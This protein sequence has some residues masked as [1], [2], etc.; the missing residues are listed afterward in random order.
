MNGSQWFGHPRGL[1]TLFFTEM[2]ERFSYYGMRAFL[3]LYMTAAVA[4]G[5]LG[6]DDKHAATVYGNYVGAVWLTPIAG[7]FIADRL[8]GQYRSVLL[9]GS[10]IAL[11]HFALA[12]KT[13]STFYAGLVLI[14]IGTGLLKPNVSTI[15]GSL[16]EDGDA[17]RDAGF[18]MFY[19]GINLGAFIG[20]IIAGGLAQKV[21]WHLGFAMAGIGMVAGLVQYVLGKPELEP[22]LARLAAQRPLRQRLSFSLSRMLR[23]I[24]RLP[25]T[26]WEWL[27]SFTPQERGRMAVIVVLFVFASVFWGAYEQAGSTL[28]LFG[29]R[30]TD[31]RVFG[32]AYPSS[33][34]VSVQALFVILLSPA[35][36]WLWLKLGP[37]QPSVPSKFAL[38]LLFG[39][40]AFLLLVPAG[41]M[42]QSAAGIKVSPLWLVAAYFIEEWGELCLS[43][44]GLSA[45]TKLAPKRIVSLMMGVFF[46]SNSLGNKLAGWTAG[47]FSS[48]PLSKLF[49][50]VAAVCLVAAVIMFALVKPVKRMMG[51]VT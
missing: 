23:S 3:I 26:L 15:V 8:L 11:G 38:A 47:F 30:Y 4:N 50:A 19:M 29:D 6:F 2:W 42:A 24:L 40:V 9:G 1:S 31:N 20:P 45:V 7:G 14:V 48:M 21:N 35:F 12:F 37:R 51:G 28:N 44:V 5:G 41:V 22:G 25:L 17:R 34:Y 18:S 46:L 16:Y 27:K 39:G 36:A 13:L 49:G 10:I 33:W 32:L 43:P